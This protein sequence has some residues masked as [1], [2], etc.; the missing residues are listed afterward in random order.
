MGSTD[1]II[2]LNGYPGVGKL[3]IGRELASMMR[4]RLLDIHTVY[5]VAIALT[6]FKSPEFRETVEKIEAIAHDLIHKLPKG[7]PVVLTSV[8][9]GESEWVE[10]EW[11]RI[12]SLGKARPPFCVVHVHCD[13]DENIRRI[14][15]EERDLKLKP[16]DPGMA[17]RNQ[18]DAKALTG[19]G[20]PNFLKLDT[21]Q[22]APLEA[23][24]TISEWAAHL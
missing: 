5:N 11:E 10:A 17:R 13:L 14:Q 15:S 7:Q 24:R 12:V 16:R 20:A 2:L 3:T 22:M 23:A 18:A 9:T 1:M 19:S 8:L 21:T 6:E 4:G